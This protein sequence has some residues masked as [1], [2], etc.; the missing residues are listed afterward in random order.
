MDKLRQDIEQLLPD[1]VFLMDINEDPHRGMVRC[2]VDSEKSIS[3]DQTSKIVKSIQHSGL[4]EKYYPDGALLEVT[5]LGI[6]E[7]LTQPF[8]YR[9]N[10]GRKLNLTYNNKSYRK[11][12]EAEL[13]GFNDD[14]LFLKNKNKGQFQLALENILQAKVI[15][16]FN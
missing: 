6:L 15:V 4:L 3:L 2:F 14:I 11:H 16:Q 7:P 9:K 12:T 10:V 13:V 8:Q 1:G 5:T